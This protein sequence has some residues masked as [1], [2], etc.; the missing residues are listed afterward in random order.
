MKERNENYFQKIFFYIKKEK[1]FFILGFLITILVSISRLVDPLILAHIVDKTIPSGSVSDLLKYS[2]FFVGVIII[3]GFLTY[4][5]NLIF[6]RLGLK[7]IT[8]LKMD[9]FSHMLKLPI[10]FFDARKVGEL[11][12]RVESDG[13]RV[14]QLFS[15]QMIMIFGNI[16][17]FIGMITVLMLK[18]SFVTLILLIP[19]SL[20]FIF[21]IFLIRYLTK[22]FKKVRE[23]YAELSAQLTEYIQGMMVIQLFNKEEKIKNIVE[24]KSKEK[25]NVET[26]TSFIEYSFWSLQTFFVETLFIIIVILLISPKIFS[27]VLT[28]GTLV[29][30]IQ[31]GLR[32]F[33]PIMQIAENFNMFQRAFVSLQRIFKIIENPTE[34]SFSGSKKITKL[35]QNIMFENVFFEYKEGEQVLKDISFKIEAGEKVAFVGPSGSGKTTT[36][37]L[38][39]G[40]YKNYKG[41]ILIDG[42]ELKEYD[43]K[44]LRELFAYIPQEGIIF[45]GDILENVRLY[46]EEISE[47][48]VKKSL[49]DVYGETLLSDEFGIYREI[50][51]KG[52]NISAGEKQFINLARVLVFSKA[53][54]VI[55][56][57]A[58]SSIDE[59]TE[60]K[61]IDALDR[62]L[63][64]K[65][66][67][68]IAH[69][70]ST[71]INCDKIFLF[72]NGNII[73]S[74]THKQLLEKSK[75]YQNI[76]KQHILKD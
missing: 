50:K 2:S 23:L 20:V 7:L 32:L 12:A 3:S 43:L 64:N 60:K 48:I 5:Q 45:P 47:D 72:E 76:V 58:T 14:K 46:D 68:I 34:E 8:S 44:S 39:L 75:E 35:K 74:G 21:S 4:I 69:R 22:F 29:I 13:E 62:I 28:V 1:L 10:S 55:M 37:N 56:D 57:E 15:S 31:Y 38:L 59:M 66:S 25:F 70:L 36:A 65:T 71:V 30:F 24:M 6:A 11:I 27:G 63:E 67:I 49:K 73:A 19:L 18:N 61:I 42:V 16:I 33:E 54:V 9:L 51:E 53:S 52:R 17:F 26:K 41:K 40:F